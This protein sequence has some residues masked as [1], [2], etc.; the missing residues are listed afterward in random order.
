MC[1]K[2]DDECRKGAEHCMH[3]ANVAHHA[4]TKRQWL[5]LARFWLRMIRPENRTASENIEAI[6]SGEP[7]AAR[8]EESKSS[9]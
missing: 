5:L 6:E 2:N 4:D 8:Q 1:D 3:M 9:H 7:A